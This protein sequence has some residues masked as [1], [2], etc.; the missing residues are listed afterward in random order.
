[1]KHILLTLSLL[2]AGNAS[3][4]DWA[5]DYTQGERKSINHEQPWGI[6]VERGITRRGEVSQRFEIRHGDCGG[7]AN[8]DD[9]TND[10]RRVEKYAELDPDDAL[11][12]TVFFGYSLYVPADFE[13]VHPSNTTVGQLKLVGYRQPM[14]D[15]RLRDDH[16]LFKADASKQECRVTDLSN[17]LGGWTDIVVGFDLDPDAKTGS[18]DGEYARVWING[19]ADECDF[20][21]PVLTRDMLRNSRSSWH[22]FH[23]D[24]GIY[25]S[26]VSRWFDRNRTKD[27]VVAEFVDTHKDSGL[28]VRSVTA[29]PWSLDWGVEFPTMV[30]YYDEIRMGYT[31][32]SVDVLQIEK[33]VD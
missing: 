7:D 10:R 11:G 13:S 24:W 32:E 22:G 17:M 19:V 8:W 3:G 16:A 18:F 21:K 25:N 26:Y 1:M 4:L 5:V 29:D 6:S 27:P 30:M 12:R 15:L 9:C 20:D 33:A 2:A 28:V 31:R 14:W 23:M